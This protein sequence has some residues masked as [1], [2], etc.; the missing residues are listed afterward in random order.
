MQGNNRYIR[1]ES[2]QD[3]GFSSQKK[4]KDS[5]VLIIGA[6]GLGS[7]AAV[8]LCAAGVGTLIL[9]DPD[10]VQIHNLHR[11]YYFT[12]E[13]CGKYKCS[14]LATHLKALNPEC[15][16]YERTEKWTEE[17]HLPEGLIPDIIL[18]GSDTFATKYSIH[19]YSRT[20]K[21]PWVYASVLEFRAE[22]S[23]FIPGS[24]PCYQC[25]YPAPPE[26]PGSCE[27]SGVLGPLPAL[28]A[29]RQALEILSWLSTGRSSLQGKLWQ[30]SMRPYTE[31]IF[32][33]EQSYDCQLHTGIFVDSA[34]PLTVLP[35]EISPEELYSKFS[36]RLT[37]TILLDIRPEAK[38]SDH[39]P[40]ILAADLSEV[41]EIIQNLSSDTEIILICASGKS[42]LIMAQK[43]SAIFPLRKILSLKGGFPSMHLPG[44]I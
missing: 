5:V 3:W 28:T 20:H 12:T 40:G 7:H 15:T 14:E 1:Q 34:P 22:I 6:G 10:I 9:Y 36:P 31:R 21:I 4:L 27:I 41:E 16:I 2:L 25:L 38:Y 44:S 39:I 8:A 35:F 19:R 13:S 18:D 24:G 23:V 29:T 26:N 42:S 37:N 11:Q 32:T 43:M 33:L 30:Y 17:S